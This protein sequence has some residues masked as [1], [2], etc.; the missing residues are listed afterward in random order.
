MAAF[1]VDITVREVGSE[2]KVP[3][4]TLESE[5]NRDFTLKDL[6]AFTK[7]SLIKISTT[8]LQEEQAK[9]FDMKP[10]LI[11]DNKFNK[12]VED[13]NPFG[14]IQYVARQDLSKI[15]MDTWEAIETRSPVDTGTYKSNNIVTFNGAF[16][17]DSRV[18]L[19]SWLE[20]KETFANKDIIRFINVSPYARKLERFAIHSGKR[21]IRRRASALSRK[22][23]LTNLMPNQMVMVPN[24]AYALAFKAIQRVYKN[25]SFIKFRLVPGN[26]LGITPNMNGDSG[27]YKRGPSKGRPYLYPTILISAVAAGLKD[28]VSAL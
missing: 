21:S 22:K 15:I 11:V 16:V 25:N 26:E 7:E 4:W 24:G 14:K 18:E 6:S 5:L 10:V 28:G 20:D 27:V 13:V 3:K 19:E 23:G 9:G 12:K 1:N 2:R 8:A 17:A